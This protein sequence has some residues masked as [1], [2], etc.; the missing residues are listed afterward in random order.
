MVRLEMIPLTG[1]GVE[2]RIYRSKVPGGWL[3]FFHESVAFYPDAG[4]AWDGG[5]LTSE[6]TPVERILEEMHRRL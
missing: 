1:C 6:E 3:V 2:D 4:H 5:S